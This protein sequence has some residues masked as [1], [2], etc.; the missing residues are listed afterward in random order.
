[1]TEPSRRGHL[2]INGLSLHHEVHGELG[3]SAPLLRALKVE[4]AD[5]MGHRR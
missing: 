5:V 3:T 1:V 2:P 4:R